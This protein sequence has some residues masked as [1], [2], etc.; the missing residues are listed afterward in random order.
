MNLRRQC[1]EI[2]DRGPVK[3]L[4]PKRDYRSSLVTLAP[5]TADVPVDPTLPE[6]GI[7]RQGVL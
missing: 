3:Q 7:M 6:G 4:G 5:T 1:G 2:T